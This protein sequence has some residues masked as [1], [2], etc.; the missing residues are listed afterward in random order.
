MSRLVITIDG[1]AGSGKSTLAK[2]LAE[3][4]RIPY[5]DTGAMYRAVAYF[6]LKQGIDIEAI[7]ELCE[8]A[9]RLQFEFRNSGGDFEVFASFGG[10]TFQKLGT[11]IR[12]PEISMGASNVARYPRLREILVRTQQDIGHKAGGVLE[13]RDAGTV[14]FPDAP[15]KFYFTASP[16][17]RAERRLK[18]LQASMGSEAPSFEVVLADVKARDY[19]DENREVSPL[20]PASDAI[21]VD[22]SDRPIDDIFHELCSKVD[23]RLQKSV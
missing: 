5:I 4:F 19:Q 11:E 3:H 15:I 9:E 14:I 2:K 8:I 6:G 20:K 17:I 22:S 1:P 13:G 12:S 7:D 23:E 16:E 18:E 21:W 10:S